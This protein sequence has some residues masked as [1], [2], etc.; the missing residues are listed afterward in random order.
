[1]PS[2]RR[3]VP[4]QELPPTR[5]TANTSEADRPAPQKT[6]HGAASR[7][8]RVWLFRLL[9]A[10]LAPILFL[11]LLEGGLR[12]FGFGYSSDF[13]LPVPGR[14][15]WTT[16]QR[17]G[18]QVFPPAIAREPQVCEFPIAKGDDTCR[19]FILGESA[20]MGVP[21]PA[22]AFSR[23][24]E[25]MLRERYPGV[26]FEVVNAAMTAIN[27]NVI[28][29]IAEQCAAKKADVL[30]VYMGNNEVIGP[31]GPGTVLA[32]YSPSRGMIRASMF[33]RTWRTG[34]F[35]HNMLRH[36]SSPVGA[37]HE[38]R[39]MEAFVGLDVTADDPR[40]ETVYK[41]FRANLE[42]ICASARE[43]GAAVLAATVAVNLKDCA[44]LSAVHAAGLP[45]A[46]REECDAH[47]RAGQELAA[48]GKHEQAAGEF[49]Q[50]LSA[51]DRFADAHFCLAQSLLKMGEIENA[52]KQFVLARDFDA[53]RFR[54][55]SRVNQTVREVAAEG[56]RARRLARRFR[57]AA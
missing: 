9:S 32:G 44:P 50:A 47:C 24:L 1:M 29:P 3:K 49:Q 14:S 20:A 28:V 40:L 34:Q 27:S 17:F 19:I 48:Q 30:I 36:D 51:D 13:F 53:L 56:P 45:A 55:D 15:A 33:V 21:E 38:W 31:F 12:L 18:W 37:A 6:V 52:R 42:A 54:A 10:I 5:P 22:F 39:G 23:M 57:E 25:V 16:N 8:R 2:K 26:R 35:L 4:M 46:R 11:C 43:R 41:C 7:R